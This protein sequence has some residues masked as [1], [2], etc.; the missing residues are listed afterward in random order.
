MVVH[1]LLSVKHRYKQLQIAYSYTNTWCMHLK[2]HTEN[3]E[4]L[5]SKK[6][7]FE[8]FKESEYMTEV[9]LKFC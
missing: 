7:M 3:I 9:I 1:A 6:N 5:Q 8:M 2:A 4:L